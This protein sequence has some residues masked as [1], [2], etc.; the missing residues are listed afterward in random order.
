[1]RSH[2]RH[3]RDSNHNEILAALA[4]VTVVRDIHNY[5]GGM[6]DILAVNVRTGQAVFLEVKPPSKYKLTPSE[7]A[8]HREFHWCS[9]VVQSVDEA[10]RA[11]GIPL[12]GPTNG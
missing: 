2:T 1:V 7:A 11:V 6:G 10:L 3:R 4:R 9:V 5:G 8:F 12:A